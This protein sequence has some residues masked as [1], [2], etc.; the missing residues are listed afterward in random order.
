MVYFPAAFICLYSLL[1]KVLLKCRYFH[2]QLNT[3][4]EFKTFIDSLRQHVQL[5]FLQSSKKMKITKV[6]ANST[7]R[8]ITH[9][10]NSR[11][12]RGKPSPTHLSLCLL[13][14]CSYQ[15]QSLPVQDQQMRKISVFHFNCKGE[16]QN[17][18]EAHIDIKILIAIHDAF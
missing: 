2:E 1:W 8:Q 15:V 16:A 9:K 12:N 17:I 4:K 13:I 5:S 10:F 7:L 11:W 6:L 3:A 18:E 14:V